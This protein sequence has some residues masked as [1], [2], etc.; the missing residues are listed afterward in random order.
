MARKGKSGKKAAPN[1]DNTKSRE[2]KSDNKVSV[3]NDQGKKAST[4]DLGGFIFMC[5]TSTKADCFKYRV[6][7]VNIGK[8]NLMEQVRKG[9][10]LFLFDVDLRLLYG[11]YV[12][13]SHGVQKLEPNAFGGEFPWQVR[14]SIQKDCLP[15]P[16]DVFQGAL[17]ENYIDKR[18]FKMELTT[19][20]VHKLAKLFRPLPGSLGSSPP[21]SRMPAPGNFDLPVDALRERR[22]GFD[23]YREE[24]L[25][26]RIPPAADR[27]DYLDRARVSRFHDTDRY[28]HDEFAPRLLSPRNKYETA[29][30]DIRRA[31]KSSGYAHAMT[32]YAHGYPPDEP[33]SF[34]G[35]LTDDIYLER[36]L[37]MKK[38][39]ADYSHIGASSLLS[40]SN[41]PPLSGSN[42]PPLSGSTLP[43][44]SAS[45][46]PPLSGSNLPPLSTSSYGT[47]PLRSLSDI[48]QPSIRDD[49]HSIYSQGSSRTAELDSLYRQ[50]LLPSDVRSDILDRRSS[51]LDA[52]DSSLAY[53]SGLPSSSL[54]R[55]RSFGDAYPASND[56]RG[57]HTLEGSSGLLSGGAIGDSGL[58][59]RGDLLPRSRYY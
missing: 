16:E 24:H 9:M 39:L 56:Y 17:K 47:D 10:R 27:F 41:L 21:R 42:L 35:R 33:R 25:P 32:K 45:N 20:Q 7:G 54:L 22:S 44:L 59:Y 14:F 3:K 36:E 18:R 51:V 12:A 5:N 55:G 29:S 50:R 28:I 31:D 43:P 8:K 19:G 49:L 57:L 11:I 53:S 48:R 37:R 1:A 4:I 6:F 38:E 40:G 23:Q 58:A 15:L 34:D 13:T 2:A 46:L 30:S 52:L 26:P